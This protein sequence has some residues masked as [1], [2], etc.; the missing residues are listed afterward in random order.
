MRLTSDLV[1]PA[2]RGSYGRE[3]HHADIA[4][5]TQQ[6]LPESA[7]HGSVA[8]ADFVA[9][10]NPLEEAFAAL[11]SEA[12]RLPRVGVTDDA[13]LGTAG[14]SAGW[15]GKRGLV[16]ALPLVLATIGYFATVGPVMRRYLQGTD[17]SS[18]AERSVV[19]RTKNAAAAG[20]A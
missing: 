6:M 5:T 2:L 1:L 10:R 18:I 12:L 17:L 19:A 8:L 3:Y 7:V 20:G 14:P 13:M 16:F 11:W 9:P 15:I 4:P